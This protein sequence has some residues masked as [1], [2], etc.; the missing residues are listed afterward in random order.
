MSTDSVSLLRQRMI[1]DM[2]ARKL[3]AGTQ[4]A[5][6][7]VASVSLHSQRPPRAAKASE[8]ARRCHRP[9]AALSFNVRSQSSGLIS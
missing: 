1:E 8:L 5:T 7:A 6:S 3:C 4:R 9:R 2:D